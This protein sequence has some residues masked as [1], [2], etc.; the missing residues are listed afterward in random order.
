MLK[1]DAH[2]GGI[3][4]EALGGMI[5]SQNEWI[6]VL[7]KETSERVHLLSGP[8]TFQIEG[9]KF[10]SSEDSESLLLEEES[11]LLIRHQCQHLN[12]GLCSLQNY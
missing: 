9:T 12:L 2:C 11:R 5:K 7:I 10:I 3:K 4:N 8:S 6:N 1:F